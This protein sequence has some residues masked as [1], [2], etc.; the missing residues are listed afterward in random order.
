M[1][2]VATKPQPIG[3]L[4][5]VEETIYKA[6]KAL[7][8]AKFNGIVLNSAK[9]DFQKDA[10][11]PDFIA[12]NPSGKVPYLE[13][14]MG[15]LF[16]SNSIAKYIARCRADTSLYGN[17]FDEEGAIDTWL[18]FCLHEL[19]IPMMSLVY[20]VFGLL[21]ED[22]SVSAAAKTDVASCLSKLEAQLKQTEY[23]IGDNV[24]LADIAI[25]C[26]LR[27]GFCRVLDAAARKPYPKTVAW[28]ERCCKLPQFS[29]VFGEI[30]LCTTP[31]KAK[32]VVAPAKKAGPPQ[33]AAKQASQP[34]AKQASKPAAPAPAPAPA[35]A[36]P[37]N[38]A[39]VTAVGDEI[40]ALK[41]KLKAEGL[42]GKKINDHPEVKAKVAQLQE[43][44]S[45]TAAAPAAPVPA[46]PAPA[47][48]KV[49][50]ADVTACG[51][52]IRKLKEKLKAEGLSG[53]KIN[54]HD[55]VKALVAKLTELKAAVAAAP[56]A[57]APAAA[58]PAAAA[59]AAGGDLDAEIKAVGDEI[60]TL[61]EKLKGEG[62][63]GKK[64]NDH[65]EVKTLVAKLQ[66]L[67]A[68][69]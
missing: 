44:K 60:R 37:V 64:I 29:S 63:S 62:L 19:E 5:F 3:T 36:G 57:P 2:P 35:S 50:E 42:S 40:R 41:E 14:D 65:A 27:D 4:H 43:L 23:L 51:D 59:P 38:D 26:A 9:F 28:F 67:K 33:P 22:A 6:Q 47:G 48:G 20:P 16:T 45:G 18:E 13:T 31:E 66:E 11:K 12:K 58:A 17:S 8:A 25:V 68:K 39:A 34:A 69:A 61:K 32:P 54:D 1:A 49:S 21:H 7:V 46:A 56:A 30:K 52:E 10:K 15:V 55:E 53:K 24:S